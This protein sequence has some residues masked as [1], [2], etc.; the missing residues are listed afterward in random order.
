M[1][2]QLGNI[3]RLKIVRELVRAG[4]A[5][6]P[7]GEIRNILGVPNSTLSHHLSH[8]RSAGL[9]RQ[10]REG[11]VLRCLVNYDHIDSIVSFLTEECCAADPA[12]TQKDK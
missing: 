8:L 4:D 11:T 3:T 6:M 7:V 5:G 2:S 9:V 10:E 1:L 12:Y